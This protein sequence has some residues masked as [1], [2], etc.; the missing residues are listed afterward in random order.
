[1][2][3]WTFLAGPVAVKPFSSSYLMAEAQGA[4]LLLPHPK[5]SHGPWF[6]EVPT[7]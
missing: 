1:M 2:A 7:E 3:L 5:S 4:Q 6:P